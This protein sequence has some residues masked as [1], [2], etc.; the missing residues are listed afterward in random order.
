MKRENPEIVEFIIDEAEGDTVDVVSLVDV[1]AIEVDFLKFNKDKEKFLFNTQNEEKRIVV[2]PCLIPLKYIYRYDV[3]SDREFY[4]FFSEAT[5]EKAMEIFMRDG[6]TR[7]SNLNHNSKFFKGL[8]VIESWKVVDENNDKAYALGYTKDDIPKGTWM[9]TFKVD[10]EKIWGDIKKGV[11]RGF[12]I[13]SFLSQM[14]KMRRE[15]YTENM[16]N[17]MFSDDKTDNEKFIELYNFLM[18]LND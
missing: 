8:T 10:D 1:P 2:G 7:E 14:V 9:I 18:K 13:E 11:Y 12:S 6:K 4:G 16:I 15:F 5:V 17:E 3:F